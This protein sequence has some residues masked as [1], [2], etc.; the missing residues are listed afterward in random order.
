MG[1]GSKFVRLAKGGYS[2]T[3]VLQRVNRSPLR[4]VVKGVASLANANEKVERRNA[5]RAFRP[6]GVE[7]NAVNDLNSRAWTQALC[8]DSRLTAELM[9]SSLALRG[10]HLGA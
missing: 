10:R 7:V 9:A 8:L 4:Y 6:Q 3:Q 5:A 2:A 1:L